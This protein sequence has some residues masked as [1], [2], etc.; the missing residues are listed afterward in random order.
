LLKDCVVVNNEENAN[1]DIRRDIFDVMDPKMFPKGPHVNI[2]C[3]KQRIPGEKWT[4]GNHS[5]SEAEYFV[6]ERESLPVKFLLHG[7]ATHTH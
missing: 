3:T 7:T 4:G 6:V 5:H 1:F 2:I